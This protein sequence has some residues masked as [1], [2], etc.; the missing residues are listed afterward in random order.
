[1]TSLDEGSRF[2]DFEHA[3]W[4]SAAVCATY[5]ERLGGVVAQVIGPMLDAAGV[6]VRDAVLDVATGS[7]EA[8]AAAA[9]RGALV[10]GVDF[11]TEM[12]RRAATNHPH[13]RFE[14]GDADALP[15]A[16]ASF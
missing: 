6:G 8:A 15:F 7:G 5:Q 14:S 13:L 4:E 11:S 16:T 10:T 1:M 3:A 9:D 12:L 2:R